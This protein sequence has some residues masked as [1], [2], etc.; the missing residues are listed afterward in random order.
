MRASMDE[1]TA[2]ISVMK[3]PRSGIAIAQAPKVFK[4][5]TSK[6]FDGK[7]S[8]NHIH[9]LM[10][11]CLFALK[12]FYTVWAMTNA[13][14]QTNKIRQRMWRKNIFRRL[15]KQTNKL[16]RAIIATQQCERLKTVRL[17]TYV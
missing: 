17:C 1:D 3:S 6:K 10:N 8:F 14:K 11:L 16:Q 2:P 9:Q 12:I 4:S 13:K 7:N 15:S 5:K